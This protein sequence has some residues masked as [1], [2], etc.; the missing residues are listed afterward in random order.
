MKLSKSFFLEFLFVKHLPVN[1]LS[2]LLLDNEC[3]LQAYII[4]HH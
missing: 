3:N 1:D 4:S 2:D